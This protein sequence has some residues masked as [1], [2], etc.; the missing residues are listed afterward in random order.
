MLIEACF[1]DAAAQRRPAGPLDCQGGLTYAHQ[2]T[3]LDFPWKVQ[4]CCRATAR[5]RALADLVALLS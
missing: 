2:V 1:G 5:R 3:D 4:P